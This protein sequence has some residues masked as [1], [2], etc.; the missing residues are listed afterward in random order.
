MFYELSVFIYFY[1]FNE[2]LNDIRVLMNELGDF[3]LSC[4]P[5]WVVDKKLMEQNKTNLINIA[6]VQ[7]I[8]KSMLSAGVVAGGFIP[9]C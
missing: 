1:F 7:C 4:E 5:E 8:Y 3:L 9:I 6:A 2:T